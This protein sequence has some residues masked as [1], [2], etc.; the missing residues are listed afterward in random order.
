[1]AK[2]R[3]R[4]FEMYEFR[5]EAT[6]AL[7]KTTAPDA[8]ESTAPES[9]S[10]EYLAASRTSSVTRVE[11]KGA[12]TFD[13]KTLSVLRED[14]SQLSERLP[15]NSQVLLDFVGVKSFCA[16]FIDELVLFNQKLRIKG[17]RMVLCN[18]APSARELFFSA[19][20]P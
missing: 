15:R 2:Y 14:F 18:L 1:M 19:R 3:H 9:W 12:E 4:I 11:F 13:E 5:E 7:M 6:L 20:S 8:T 17:S 10:L 16:A